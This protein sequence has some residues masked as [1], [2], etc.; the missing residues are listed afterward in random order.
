[1]LFLS[2]PPQQSVSQEIGERDG[3]LDTEGIELR[4]EREIHYD[5]RFSRR[6]LGLVDLLPL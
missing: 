3:H 6:R 4:C 1:M 2:S 5:T